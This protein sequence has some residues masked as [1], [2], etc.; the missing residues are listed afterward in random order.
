MAKPFL[1][2]LAHLPVAPAQASGPI[3]FENVGTA[4]AYPVWNLRGP[5]SNFTATSPRGEVLRWAGTLEPDETLTIDTM[6]GTVV[7]GL[8]RNRYAELDTA[9]RMWT[10]PPGAS[11][12]M[13]D[14][15]GTSPGSYQPAGAVVRTNSFSNPNFENGTTGV[16]SSSGVTLDNP[17]TSFTSLGSRCLRITGAA[18]PTVASSAVIQWSAAGR[19]TD[20]QW[21]ATGLFLRRSGSG[22][23]FVRLEFQW[24]L[25]STLVSATRTEWRELAAS[26]NLGAPETRHEF[27]A[28]APSGVDRARLVLWFSKNA[29]PDNSFA[30][31]PDPGFVVLSDGWIDGVGATKAAA[32][33][34]V[35]TFFDG[36]TLSDISGSYAWT[37]ATNA[38]PS[39]HRPSRLA[40]ASRVAVSWR[41]RK[42]LVI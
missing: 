20:G 6:A 32:L 22:A 42:W 36:S 39:T 17:S 23:R 21:W 10:V 5:G 31:N 11:V 2:R 1:S 37:G 28:Q 19:V 34:Q 4:D 12:G 33:A 3:P 7:D 25:G 30:D 13:V 8:G 14:F 24:Y 18:A 40:G 29:A 27:A 15:E 41:A 16:S 38:S 9:P 35:A 26:A